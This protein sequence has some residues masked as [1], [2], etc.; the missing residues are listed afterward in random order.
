[1]KDAVICLRISKHLRSALERMSQDD[2]RSLSST[3][4]NI[5]YA[6]IEE[7]GLGD[8]AEEKRHY[9]RKK[10]SAPALL[11]GPDGTVYAGLVRNISLGG[12]GVAAPPNFPCEQAENFRMSVVFTLPKSDTPLAVQCIPKHVREGPQVYVGASFV[13]DGCQTFEAIRRHFVN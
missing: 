12:I 2:R 4:Q 1:M 9:L 6:H 11:S 13:D 10:I 8:L 3:V 5:L 7:R